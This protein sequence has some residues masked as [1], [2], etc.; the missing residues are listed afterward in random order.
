M[1]K[2]RRGDPE[3]LLVSFCD[4]VTITTAAMFLAMIIVIDQ[5]S[6][7]PTVRPMPMLRS[8]TNS[9]VY[10]ECRAGHVFPIF[11]DKLA[12]A[13]K[14]EGRKV[15]AANLRQ[16]GGDIQAVGE[17]MK[18]DIGD[19]YY[20]L[21]SHYLMLGIMA[22]VPREGVLGTSVEELLESPS[23]DFRKIVNAMDKDAQYCAFLV[24]DDSFEVFRRARE[25][26]STKN[27]T[28]GWELLDHG[29]PITFSGAQY[30]LKVQ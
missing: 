11:R 26:V 29:E 18:L 9:A 13:F 24:R 7:V 6:R 8:T 20:R 27:F 30:R 10:F 22:L 3:L 2:I 16:A 5:S 15:A 1:P 4:I 28:A 17:I 21:D 19:E 23:N 25:L 12:E 14:S